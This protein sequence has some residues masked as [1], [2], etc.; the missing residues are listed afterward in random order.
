[1]AARSAIWWTG[2]FPGPRTLVDATN[3]LNHP[4]PAS[5]NFT[6]GGTAF[7]QIAGPP[8][9]GMMTVFGQATPVQPNFQNQV[10]IT[11]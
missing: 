1:M 10:R 5:P 8:A 4:H 6:V 2:C 9:K 7:G 11:F 3:I